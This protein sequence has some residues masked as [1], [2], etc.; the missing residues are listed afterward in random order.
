MLWDPYL[1]CQLPPLSQPMLKL[2]NY[3]EGGRL[4]EG[5]TDSVVESFSS[6]SCLCWDR[7]VQWYSC[8]G[9][10]HAVESSPLLLIL[11]KCPIRWFTKMDKG[12]VIS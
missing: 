12:E 9:V 1:E 5:Q 7:A 10:I 3:L 2:L 8:F 11:Q 4:A 6:R